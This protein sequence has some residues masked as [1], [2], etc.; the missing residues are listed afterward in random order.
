MKCCNCSYLAWKERISLSQAYLVNYFN[1]PKYEL[2]C[3]AKN[4]KCM[5]ESNIRNEITC[6]CFRK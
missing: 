4:D 5:N 1:E 6:D 3:R 2:V